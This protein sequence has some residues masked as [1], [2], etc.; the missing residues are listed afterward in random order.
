MASTPSA[1]TPRPKWMSGIHWETSPPFR[2]EWLS[3]TVVEFYR[4]GHLKNSLNEGHA[5]VVAKDGQEIEEECGRQLLENMERVA[6]MKYDMHKAHPGKKE[7]RPRGGYSFR[8]GRG[9]K[10]YIKQ[11]YDRGR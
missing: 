9:G 10:R 6:E 7:F 3:T 4:I 8:G 2:V 1:D 5:V 11:E